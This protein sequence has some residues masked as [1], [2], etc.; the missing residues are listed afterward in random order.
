M[1]WIQV[2]ASFAPDLADTSPLVEAFRTFGVENTLERSDSI[3]GCLTDVAGADAVGEK[4]AEAL[5]SA[6]ALDVEL[7][8]LPETDW[9]NA[10]KQFFKP[11]RVGERFL[12]VPTW[13]SV[14]AEAGDVVLL[15]DPGQAFG[16]GDHPTTRMCLELLESVDVSGRK[17]LD[18][19][20]GS[21]ILAIA[22][23][24]LGAEVFGSDIDPL[25]VEVA[26]ENA[27]RNGVSVEFWAGDGFS[28]GLVD[29]KGVPQDETPLVSVPGSSGSSG[30]DGS[31][32]LVLSNIISATLI[33]LAHQVSAVVN[34]G[35][36]WIVSGIID[37]NWDDVRTAA[38]GADFEL[39]QTLHEDGWVAARF[40]RLTVGE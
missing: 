34:P 4:L 38:E 21:G 2:T 35:G 15:L 40:T 5:R 37:G 30:F 39:A 13:E 20:C 8:P 6:G 32:D 26:R 14:S 12:I 16:T 9:E 11:R 23:A 10:W 27:L 28:R 31:Y 7:A 22:A 29:L 1:S 36:A 24:K 19:G 18:L 17:V 3:T 25:A 33:R